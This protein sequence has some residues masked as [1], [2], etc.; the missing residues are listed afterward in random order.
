VSATTLAGT[1]GGVRVIDASRVLAGPYC[2]QVLADL[3]AEVIKVEAP[4]EGDE[5]RGWGPPFLAGAPRVAGLSAY[6][7]SCNRGKRSVVLDLKQTTGRALLHR[8]IAKSDV[9]L[10]NFRGASLPRLGLTPREL[11]AVNPRLVICSITGYGRGTAAERPGYDFVVQGL[12][13]MMAATGPE[14]GPPAK[15]G[16]AIA[17]IVTGLY[18]ATAV[19]AALRG[20]EASGHG[21]AIELALLDCAV[22]AMANVAQS[23]LSSGV[24]PERLGNAHLQI[25]PYQLFATAD[26][27]LVLAVG[28]DGQWRRFCAAAGASALADEARWAT[29]EGRVRGRA[30]LVPAVAALL[31]GKTTSTWE[32]LLAQAEVPC[33]PVWDFAQ[34]F[35]SPLAGERGLK[36]TVRRPDGTPVDLVR[37][38]LVPGPIGA[39]PPA[40][41]EHT[42]AV[43]AEVLGLGAAELATLAKAGVIG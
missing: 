13:G 17:D 4:G 15:V 8:L 26:G 40:H 33:G 28:N 2:G 34:L 25:V 5:T 31:K 38:P 35:A 19:L 24:V 3:G 7:L 37:S 14:A 39:P 32:S 42:H 30:A 43:L 10:E 18:A 36:V 12:S 41:G 27:W 6:F 21:Y 1:L 16:V 9:L 22:A 23:Y 29:N 20:R 11:H